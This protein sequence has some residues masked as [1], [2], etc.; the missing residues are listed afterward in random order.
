MAP[1][2]FGDIAKVATE[3]FDDDYQCAGIQLKNKSKT[4]YN[5]AVITT[6]VDV[7]KDDKVQ[8]PAKLSWKFPNALGVSGLTVDKFEMDKAGK[9]KC[10]ASCDKALHGVSDLKL[11]VKSDCV[12]FD[13][14]NIGCTFTGLKDTMVMLD[15]PALKPDAFNLELMRSFGPVTAGAKLG[16]ASLMAP[17]VGCRYVSGPIFASLLATSSFSVFKCHAFYKV[18]DD[19]KLAC[20]YQQSSKPDAGLGAVYKINS[21]TSIKAKV[22][23]NQD[24]CTTVKYG[25]AKGFTVLFGAKYNLGGGFKGWGLQV[26]LE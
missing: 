1:V 22:G 23:M 5:G 17:D 21:D 25:L 14:V 8:T 13:K 10:E 19:V 16:M 26:S 24:I 20:F 3:V 11:E 7:N 18:S 4:G 15:A 6:T 2:K 12:N 9:L